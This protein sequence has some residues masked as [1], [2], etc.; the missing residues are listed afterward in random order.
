MATRAVLFDAY[1][2][3]LDVHYVAELAELHWPGRGE[4]LSTLWRDKQLQYSWLRT[5]MQNYADFWQITGDALD[6]AVSRLGLPMTVEVRDELMGAYER[7]RVF[8]DV[9]PMLM[10]LASAG[11]PLAVLSNG[12]PT[13]L[14]KAFGAAGL[15][16]AF[17]ALL[18]VDT[19]RNYKTSPQAYQIAIDSFGGAPEDFV[20]VSSNGWDIAGAAQFGFRTF[21]VNRLGAPTERLGVAPSHTGNNLVELA[22]W[23]LA[24]RT[25]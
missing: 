21:W 5:L 1:G 13:M 7:L 8:P 15:R 14:E 25:E 18:S 2:T 4:T 10:A 16:A 3:L 23:L 22:P 11:V 20:L 17:T 6:Y 9:Q 19:A 24:G 12:T